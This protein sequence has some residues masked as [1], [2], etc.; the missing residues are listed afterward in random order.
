M[1]FYFLKLAKKRDKKNENIIIQNDDI[2]SR[3]LSRPQAGFMK[4]LIN[5]PN[6]SVFSVNEIGPTTI[7][8]AEDLSK[9]IPNTKIYIGTSPIIDAAKRAFKG[10]GIKTKNI[11]DRIAASILAAHAGLSGKLSGGD[12]YSPF[13]DIISVRSNIPSFVAHEI[14]HVVD[15][16]KQDDPVKYLFISASSKPLIIEREAKATEFAKKH[17]K[18][19]KESLKMLDAALDTYSS[20]PIKIIVRRIFNTKQKNRKK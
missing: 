12:Y 11:S 1:E 7:S 14:G 19:G 3:I 17:L 6:V 20:G 4:F 18:H 16:H 13:A 9:Y 2:I 8:A 5:N 15:F 10:E